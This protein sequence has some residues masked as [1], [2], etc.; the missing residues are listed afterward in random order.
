MKICIVNS[1]YYPDIIGGAELSVLKLAEA[2]KKEGNEVHILCTSDKNKIEV[3]NDIVVHRVKIK[4]ICDP[5]ERVK[6]NN[7]SKITKG[8]YSLIDIYNIMNYFCLKKEL[9]NISPEVLHIN[10]INGISMIIWS[11]ARK[12]KIPIIQTL[13]DYSLLKNSSKIS[14]RIRNPVYRLLS[15][16]V[17]YVTAPSK[18]TLD[19]FLE[20]KYF[21]KAECKVVYNAIDYLDEDI[22]KAIENKNFRYKNGE[23]IRF[24]FLG[25][26]D[27]GK[28]IQ[29]LI[30]TF[31]SITNNNIQLVIAGDGDCKDYVINESY[32]DKRIIYKGFLDEKGVNELLFNSDVLIIPSL[33]PEP[34]GRVIIEAYKYSMPVIGSRIGG[35]P[36]VLNDNTGILINAGDKDQLK[37]AIE[38]LSDRKN[39][40][41]YIFNCAKEIEKYNIRIQVSE[42]YDI[43]Q[44]VIKK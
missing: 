41:K 7:A 25:R 5:I 37:K 40:V 44:Y 3:I 17:D 36:E 4:N 26:L 21:E 39:I 9:S 33:W 31:R 8:L 28:G 43:Y 11:V 14:D 38:Y 42:F 19:K 1:F 34:F 10:N 24:V 27:S 13:R 32:N 15:S 2:L 22:K 6:S 35:I 18:Y 29:F 16:K 12:L 30:E 23:N 20:N